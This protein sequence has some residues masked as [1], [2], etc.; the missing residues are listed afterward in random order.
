MEYFEQEKP[1]VIPLDLFQCPIC[2][3]QIVFTEINEYE[4]ETGKVTDG[5]FHVSCTTEPDFD[6]P[7]YDD[8]MSSHFSMPYVDWLPLEAR[9]YKWL[10]AG[11][12]VRLPTP[13]AG[14][15]VI[16]PECGVDRVDDGSCFYCETNPNPPA[17][18]A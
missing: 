13:L 9:V 11:Y 17:A 14:G 3:A 12:R 5:G 10:S 15:R 18:K 6:D 16:C 4:T 7:D 2:G 1:P 8:F